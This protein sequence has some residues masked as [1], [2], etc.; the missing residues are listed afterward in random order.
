M[1][2]DSHINLR[3]VFVVVTTFYTLVNMRSI[4]FFRVALVIVICPPL[5]KGGWHGA[6]VTGGLYVLRKC[7]LA[8]RFDNPSVKNQRFLPAVHCGMTA[9]GSHGNFDLLRGAPPFAQG[10]RWALFNG[11]RKNREIA[12]LPTKPPLGNHRIFRLYFWKIYATITRFLLFGGNYENPAA[13]LLRTLR[14]PS[15]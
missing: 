7:L 2:V 9:T 6:A 5:C 14:Q 4:Y 11:I 13:H 12:A 10:S 1:C 8:P 3:V 15:H